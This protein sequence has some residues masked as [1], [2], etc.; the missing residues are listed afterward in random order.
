MNILRAIMLG[1]DDENAFRSGLLSKLTL[2]SNLQET[3]H[4]DLLSALHTLQQR[5]QVMS[6]TTSDL[7]TSISQI[8][9][10]NAALKAQIDAAPAAI[11]TLVATAIAKQATM[12][13][14]PAQLQTLTD[15]HTVLGGETEQL[16]Q[17]LAGVAPPPPAVTPPAV[18][19]PVITPPVIT[20]PATPPAPTVD[21]ATGLPI[22]A[23]TP[24]PP[25]PPG[26]TVNPATGLPTG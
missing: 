2:L 3:R 18:T 9:S 15:L 13:V 4:R 6:A 10:D 16:K 8:V 22:P 11:A 5:M 20:P 23:V 25:L 17:A 26:S 7:D 24:P 1:L 19:P 21:P 12:G 14:T